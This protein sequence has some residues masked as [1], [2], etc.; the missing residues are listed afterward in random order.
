MNAN[1][2]YKGLSSLPSDY[3]CQDGELEVSFGIGFPEEDGAIRQECEP[4][5]LL[6]LSSDWQA[7]CIHSSVEYKHY[8]LVS[9]AQSSKVAY[10]DEK[11]IDDTTHA[12]SQ[13]TDITPYT[14]N[15]GTTQTEIPSGD[16]ITSVTPMGNT[17]VLTVAGSDGVGYMYYFLWKDGA[18]KGL[19]S[20]IPDVR[21]QFSL[22]AFCKLY[23]WQKYDAE[24]DDSY[25][26]FFKVKVPDRT[27]ATE[28]EFSDNQK[29]AVKSVVMGKVNKF[30]NQVGNRAGKFVFPFLVRYAYRLYDGSYTMHSAPVLMVPCT[31][32][33]LV[34]G[35]NKTSSES[36]DNLVNCDIFLTPCRLN[37]Q[38]LNAAA[39]QSLRNEWKDIVTDICIFVSSPFYTYDQ[40]GD[41]EGL[42]LIRRKPVNWY[43]EPY[44]NV[45]LAE[46]ANE[47]N[48]DW[49]SAA[50]E[51]EEI[52]HD[53]NGRNGKMTHLNGGSTTG[54]VWNA[55]ISRIEL[56]MNDSVRRFQWWDVNELFKLMYYG[57]AQYIYGGDN[58]ATKW[59]LNTKSLYQIRLAEFEKGEYEDKIKNCG[60]FYLLYSL[61]LED[62]T[63]ESDITGTTKVKANT[64][65]PIKNLDPQYLGNLTAHERLSDDY[66][67]H[68][69]LSPA[70]T[71][72]Y[73]SRLHIGNVTKTVSNGFGTDVMLPY[74][75]TYRDFKMYHGKADKSLSGDPWR[76]VAF[77]DTVGYD[78][79]GT[80][81]GEDV[82]QR[83]TLNTDSGKEIICGNR[84]FSTGLAFNTREFDGETNRVLPCYIFFPSPK[85]TNIKVFRR[86]GSDE[87]YRM[88]INAKM[89]EHEH[90]YG[91]VYLAGVNNGSRSNLFLKGEVP[92]LSDRSYTE[93]NIVYISEA[94]NPFVFQ[95]V[96]SVSVGDG[97]IIT[98]VPAVTA[99]SQGQFGEYPMY[100][101]TS[102]GVWALNPDDSGVYNTCR[103]VSRDVCLSEKAVLQLD[104]SVV[105]A[106]KRGVVQISGSQT[107]CISNSVNRIGSAQWTSMQGVK[108]V[109]DKYAVPAESVPEDVAFT[110]Y[111]A[112]ACMLYDYI[113]SRIIISNSS[114]GYAYVYY[115]K[116]AA[117]S[118][119]PYIISR[120][121]NSYPNAVGQNEE[122]NVVDLSVP[123]T[124]SPFNGMLITRPFKFGAPDTFKEVSSIIQR[125]VVG[126]SK[127]RQVLYGSND[128][129]NWQPIYSSTTK[130][131]R[132]YRGTPYKYFKIAVFC[133]L[134]NTENLVGFS[135]DLT[136]R[137]N[138][139][140]R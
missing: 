90:L 117:W 5:T 60:D 123:D 97:E 112:N 55:A 56:S 68:E 45:M 87:N 31:K 28:L 8:I 38:M 85:A 114:Y 79:K 35:Q 69:Q 113:A 95:A 74:C 91:S 119:A 37:W 110:D 78:G 80:K 131:M 127:I 76:V 72:V 30:V 128:L 89:E 12:P 88:V 92:A 44:E 133:N 26:E 139:I 126:N 9:T 83:Y 132:G 137:L 14:E 17:L 108:S 71:R 121:L 47:T 124:T 73:N 81:F 6:T 22:T 49:T 53:F 3:S 51:D 120:G 59:M 2:I 33:P 65:Y 101:F 135:A 43:T 63:I 41:P 36:T 19:G 62:G 134:S 7:M 105:F 122:G 15:N 66:M 57:A 4:S 64:I 104:K 111:V 94:N 39:Y 109:M 25:N 40:S 98:L 16:I 100:A 102:E 116:S 77:A 13:I 67:S 10:V 52:L 29:S 107:E 18:Y 58:L 42:T 32:Q 99:L 129:T 130:Y 50:D 54:D 23:S 138:D 106:T 96:N 84:T 140:L 136:P 118:T 82:V 86:N 27:E 48:N 24:D 34:I 21:I 75:N 1:V 11:D 125:G 46:L 115:M 93:Q 61:D 20:S 70:M 103:P